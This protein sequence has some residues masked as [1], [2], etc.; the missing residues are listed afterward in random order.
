MRSPPD[1]IALDRRFR[2][3]RRLHRLD[4]RGRSDR[5]R[6]GTE[7]ISCS[8]TTIREC[9]RSRGCGA[10]CDRRRVHRPGRPMAAVG[11]QRTAGRAR[12]QRTA[13]DSTR[14]D[15]AGCPT[16]IG[17]A[18]PLRLLL[19]HTPDQL[20]WARDHDF[21]LMLAGTRMAG[22]FACR[23]SDRSSARAVT[24]WSTLQ[25]YFTSRRQ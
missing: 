9:G 10:R 6:R 8:A 25:V 12:W 17:G 4:S 14:A 23:G 24:D 7:S 21:D 2:G 3:Q 20:P 13:V 1:L 18:R 5:S 15:M 19:A 16:E 11:N 22:R